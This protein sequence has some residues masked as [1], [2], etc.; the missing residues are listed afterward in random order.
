[1]SS[2]PWSSPN[3]GIILEASSLRRDL[4]SQSLS[5]SQRMRDGAESSKLKLGISGDQ[6]PL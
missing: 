4:P 1:M 6:L 3:I 2:P 5:L